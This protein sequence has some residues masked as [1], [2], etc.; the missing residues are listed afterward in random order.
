MRYPSSF[1]YLSM[2]DCGVAPWTVERKLV[3]FAS[4]GS[5]AGSCGAGAGSG[6][7][8]G[9]S[10]SGV[11]SGGSGSAS[12]CGVTEIITTA[13]AVCVP[14]VAMILTW[15]DSPCALRSDAGVHSNTPA[16]LIVAPGGIAPPKLHVRSVYDDSVGVAVNVSVEPTSTDFAGID[17]MDSGVEK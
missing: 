6:L 2:S 7:G 14:S 5:G 12:A 10:G 13:P 16:L 17:A 15:N 4:I 3:R 8:A 11:V 9:G 1:S